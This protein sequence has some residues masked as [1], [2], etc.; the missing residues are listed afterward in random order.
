MTG[1][2]VVSLFDERWVE[3]VFI[4]GNLWVS[5]STKGRVR[6]V[7]GDG[8]PAILSLAQMAELGAVLTVAFNREEEDNVEVKRDPAG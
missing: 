1:S 5:I 6:F 4:G 7:T 3:D 8:K 2:N